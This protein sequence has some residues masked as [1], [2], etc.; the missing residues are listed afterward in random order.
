MIPPR[1]LLQSPFRL[2]A[3][4]ALGLSLGACQKPAAST[5]EP[6]AVMSVEL[7]SPQRAMWNETLLASGN[8]AAWEEA[9]IGAEVGGTRLLQV[10]VNVGDVVRKG[11]ELARLDPA[12]LEAQLRQRDAELAQAEAALAAARADADRAEQLGQAGSISQQEALRYRTDYATAAA[13]QQLALA[14][15]D[16]AALN[17]RYARVLAPDD[18]VISARTA[19]VGS[20]VSSG[21]ELFRMIRGQRLEWQAEVPGDELGRLQPGMAV[22]LRRPDG[23]EL[24]GR[25]RQLAPTVNTSTRS[26]L[27]YV[28]LP[29]DS[30]L[31]AGQFV[32]GE[33]R[34]REREAQ[35]LPESSIVLRDGH[36][37]VMNVTADR[38]V[39]QIKV[40][41]GRRRDHAIE[42]VSALAADLQLIR[43]GGAFLGDGDLVSI[44][45][46]Q[47][48]APGAP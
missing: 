14:Q 9:V 19:T 37:Y 16:L 13:Q 23:S 33:F 39:Q 5:P 15:R 47:T 10:Q 31:H 35:Y 29:A 44:A 12:L 32:S 26:A 27:A 46:P 30:G 24:Q 2:A 22:M 11:Q 20:L 8:V 48:T 38:H 18:G 34:L 28:D 36:S 43:A 40:E 4:L 45:A 7:V 17:L 21:S 41:T 3:L 42:I 6:Q 25:L 1:P